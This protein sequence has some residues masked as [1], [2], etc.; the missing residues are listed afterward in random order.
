MSPDAC[1][2]CGRVPDETAVNDNHKMS[3]VYGPRHQSKVRV[4]VRKVDYPA[5]H[6]RGKVKA[7]AR[8]CPT[9]N[10]SGALTNRR[11]STGA[12]IC[13]WAASGKCEV[14]EMLP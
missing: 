6:D 7:E 13:R 10:R 3:C 5:N 2:C 9:C 11:D 12:R 14:R 8:R 4:T 1:R